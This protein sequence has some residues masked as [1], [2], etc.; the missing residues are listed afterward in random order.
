MSSDSFIEDTIPTSSE[1]IMM[2][3]A[4]VFGAALL[5]TISLI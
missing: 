4:Y 5:L 3:A 2:R 1:G